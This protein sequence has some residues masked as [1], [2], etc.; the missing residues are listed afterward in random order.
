MYPEIR[1]ESWFAVARIESYSMPNNF[2]KV[3]PLGA[4]EEIIKKGDI[5]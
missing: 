1:P 3:L 5:E 4:G 2:F